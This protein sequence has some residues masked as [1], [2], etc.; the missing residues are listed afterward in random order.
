MS[1]GGDV[2]IGP[3]DV[4]LIGYPA[5]SPLTG[6]AL[7]ILL[8]LVDRGIVRVLDVLFVV[9]NEDGTISG[10]AAEDLDEGA[11]GDL[12]AFE[13]ASSGLLGDEDA[14][15]AAEAMEPGEAAALLMY[16]NRWAAPFVAAVRRNGGQ[17]L[18]GQRIP[19]DE[20]AEAL[21]RLDAA[22]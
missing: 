17:L 9:K 19:A 16:E 12:V 8:D 10:F 11:H 4:I 5:G 1:D 21:A 20:L 2:E 18:A 3:V 15:A 14:A 6:E 13:G 7:P 22:A